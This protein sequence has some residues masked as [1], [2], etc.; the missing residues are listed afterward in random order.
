MSINA[1]ILVSVL[2]SSAVLL[3]FFA[4]W[5]LLRARDPVEARLEQYGPSQYAELTRGSLGSQAQ[6]RYFDSKFKR[7]LA[8]FGIG[9]RLGLAL[10]R[11]DVPMTAV[12][13]TLVILG[14]GV[15][16]FALGT[17][18]F[19]PWLGLALALT[20]A[21][22][23]M[24]YLRI[25]QRRR[26]RAFT[27]QLPDMLTLLVGALRAGYGLTQSLEVLVERLSPPVS[28]ELERVTRALNLGLPIKE[29]LQDMA[30]RVGSD[31]L[32]LVVIAIS[33]QHDIGGN[34]A[35]TL[36]IISD[37]VQDRL[38]ML[39]EIRVLTAQQRFTGFVLA[40]LPLAAGLMIFT[41]NPEYI[42]RLFAPGWVR[43]LPAAA[44]VLQLLGYFII[45]RIVDIE[46]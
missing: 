38:R 37:T 39:R 42:S 33:V 31:D 15:L 19:S 44:V 14:L 23:P 21:S 28:D 11:A 6:Q 7:F 34:L 5:V 25:R 9:P 13:F 10:V 22:L 3:I 24:I 17:V 29:A 4:L 45:S 35:E 8:G 41:I 30:E 2:A 20:F 26:L 43:L 1:P 40:F 27:E 32:D 18:R 12:E 16:G 36:E 46:V